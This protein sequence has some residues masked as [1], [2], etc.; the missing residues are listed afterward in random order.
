MYKKESNS[1]KK[2]IQL[3]IVI[4]IY[5]L[6]SVCSKIVSDS[7]NSNGLISLKTIVFLGIL[8]LSLFIYAVFWQQIIKKVDL[9]IAYVNKGVTIL[10]S[11]FWAGILFNETIRINS[12]IGALIVIV[13]IVVVNYEQ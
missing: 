13:G 5:T 1:I 11:L 3:H 10:W 8:F 12:L 6:S 2:Y 9:T 7:I 4:L